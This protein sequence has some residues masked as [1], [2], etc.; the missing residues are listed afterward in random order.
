MLLNKVP[1]TVA[2][3][4]DKKGS[5]FKF[6]WNRHSGSSSGINVTEANFSQIIQLVANVKA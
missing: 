3:I 2:D 1:G 6:W 4:G 5:A